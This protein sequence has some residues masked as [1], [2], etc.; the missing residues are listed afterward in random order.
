MLHLCIIYNKK[1]LSG[2]NS[3]TTPAKNSITTP[4]KNS[5]TMLAKNSITMPTKNSIIMPAKKTLRKKKLYTKYYTEM[6]YKKD[7][8]ASQKSIQMSL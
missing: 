2:K 1:K 7:C 6:L 4:A 8:E 5:I 3:I